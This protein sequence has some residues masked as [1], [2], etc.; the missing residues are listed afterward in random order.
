MALDGTYTGLQT[1][2]ADWL[3]RPG[4]T[5]ITGAVPDMIVLYEAEARDRLRTRFNEVKTTITTTANVATI[6]VPSMFESARELLLQPSANVSDQHVLIYRTPEN[7][8]D[9]NPIVTNDQ[10]PRFF[11]VEGTNFRFAPTPDAAYT[12]QVTYMQGIPAL[13]GSA[14]TNWLLTNYPDAYLFGSLAMASMYIGHDERMPAWV[15]LANNAIN[16][17][18]LADTKVRWSGEQLQ[19]HTDTNNP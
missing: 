15:G 4:D 11:T 9:D 19:M 12:I 7:L 3:A 13:T 5:L 17:I 10:R 1:S 8:D 16:R 2:I 18:I 6:A 14:P